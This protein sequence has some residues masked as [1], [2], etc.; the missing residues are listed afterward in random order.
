MATQELLVP[1]QETAIQR[2]PTVMQILADAVMR[3]DIGVEVIERLAA[4]QRQMMQD[5]AELEFNS[6]MHRCQMKMKPIAADMT[7]SHTNSKYA[8]FAQIDKVIRPIYT[9]EDISLSFSD[10][11]PPAVGWLR[12]LCYV[13]RKGYTRVYHKD[14]PLVTVGAQ[15]KAVMTAI[16]AQ[17]S[18]D[19]YAKR[20][21]IKDIFNVA[22]GEADD[23]GNG[24]QMPEPEFLSVLDN[25][26]NATPEELKHIYIAGYRAAQESGDT[27][28]M[29]GI[30]AA[31]DK[32]KAEL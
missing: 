7:N 11:E 28:A 24:G 26:A 30:V 17:G 29:A 20:Y 6:A 22:V 21:L 15:G 19:A 8:S 2:E 27:A 12:I 1:K 18:S 14:M 5:Q 25:I 9:A 3:K 31:K 32:R 10:G 4:L 16:H 13:S 23:D